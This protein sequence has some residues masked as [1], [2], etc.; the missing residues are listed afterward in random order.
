MTLE[1][2][3]SSFTI[4]G[5]CAITRKGLQEPFFLFLIG[6]DQY[7]VFRMNNDDQR[8]EWLALASAWIKEAREGR[9]CRI[10]VERGAAAVL[11]LDLCELMIEAARQLQFGRD[12]YRVADVPDMGFIEEGSYDLGVSY[13]SQCDLPNFNANNREVFR[14]LKPGGRF[15]VA[16]LHPMRLAVGGWHTSEKGTKE[17][18]ILDN[19][20]DESDRSWPM[21]GVTITGFHRTLAT[22]LDGFSDA[23]FTLEEIVEPT[24]TAEKVAQYPELDD[25]M[26]VPNFIIYTM[27]KP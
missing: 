11:G 5:C 10:L 15:L 27:R 6:E 17:H 7:K 22:Y 21:K 3:V 25:E 8:R 13:L 26:R 18:V 14:V 23:G 16:N 4:I 1:I 19:Y 24:V 20:F 2:A 12:E 9:F